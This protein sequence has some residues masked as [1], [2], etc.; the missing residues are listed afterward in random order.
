MNDINTGLLRFRS[1]KTL[2]W[3]VD[4]VSVRGAAK[5]LTTNLTE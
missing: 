5:Y 4:A 2:L 1:R 3:A